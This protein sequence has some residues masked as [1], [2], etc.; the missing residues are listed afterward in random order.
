MVKKFYLHV[1]V[2]KKDVG[3]AKAIKMFRKIAQTRKGSY[4][5]TEESFR[6]KNID[7]NKFDP[8][9][10]S[11]KVINDKV[12]VIFGHLKPAYDIFFDEDEKFDEKKNSENNLSP[13]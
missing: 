11:S 10:F 8:T 1:V 13:E 12:T 2:I 9:T 4:V 7:K 3:I 5:E 6:F